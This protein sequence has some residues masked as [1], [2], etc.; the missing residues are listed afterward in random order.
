MNRSNIGKAL[1]VVGPILFLIGFFYGSWI[2][3]NGPCGDSCGSIIDK[4][5]VMIL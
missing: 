2:A 3:Y 1:L 4:M 5:K